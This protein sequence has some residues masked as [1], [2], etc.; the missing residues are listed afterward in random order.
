MPEKA[1][2]KEKLIIITKLND[3]HCFR[4]SS[5]LCISSSKTL[6]KMHEIYEMHSMPHDYLFSH[7]TCTTRERNNGKTTTTGGSIRHQMPLRHDLN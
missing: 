4:I 6:R 2:K 7:Y 5:A 1:K 3:C